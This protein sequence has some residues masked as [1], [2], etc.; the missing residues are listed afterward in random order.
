MGTAA[1]AEIPLRYDQSKAAQG[2]MW[3]LTAA[4]TIGAAV[5]WPIGAD[6]SVHVI[7]AA[8]AG[9]FNGGT[10]KILG[11]NEGAT[12]ADNNGVTPDDTNNADTIEDLQGTDLAFT[13]TGLEGLGVVPRR[14]WPKVTAGTLGSAPGVYVILLAH[15]PKRG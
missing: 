10:V 2:W 6:M 7:G 13:A 15:R 4:N 1:A 5:E 3:L 11:S 12:A 14:I 9:G 8:G